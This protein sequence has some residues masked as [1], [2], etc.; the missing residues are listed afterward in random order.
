[1][2]EFIVRSRIGG[3]RDVFWFFFR[4]A[5]SGSICS[6]DVFL[7]AV[8]TVDQ[9]VYI[10]FKFEL[11]LKLKHSEVFWKQ[12]FLTFFGGWLGSNLLKN[13]VSPEKM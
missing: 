5:S 12:E 9:D 8:A 6:R 13:K 4:N 1:M 10:M 3:V 11:E 7:T 2:N